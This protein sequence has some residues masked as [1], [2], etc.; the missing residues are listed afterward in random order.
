[1]QPISLSS[2]GGG[3]GL[4]ISPMKMLVFAGNGTRTF[5]PRT[6][7]A[8]GRNE[9]LSFSD[10]V[11]NVYS[12]AGTAAGTLNASAAIGGASQK[13]IES[14]CCYSVGD[15]CWYFLATSTTGCRLVKALPDGTITTPGAAFVFAPSLVGNFFYESGANVVFRHGTTA[16][17]TTVTTISKATG[18]IVTTTTD[19]V[20]P[21]YVSTDG[22]VGFSH[23]VF[24]P[25]DAPLNPD[26]SF[27]QGIVQ[28]H[29]LYFEPAAGIALHLPVMQLTP[30]DFFGLMDYR[31]ISTY[32][33]NAGGALNDAASKITPVLFG[34]AICFGYTAP[35]NMAKDFPHVMRT[36]MDRWLRDLGKKFQYY[37][38]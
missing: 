17:G 12:S 13:Y 29:G 8:Y 18:Q 6:V 30:Q 4:G 3:F 36:E 15:S 20:R 33:V 2:R 38:E 25:F 27:G 16:A 22:N 7:P 23:I 14:A 26:T 19:N 5:A 9:R 34:N 24:I 32:A 11:V 21:A 1:M 37:S 35:H 31:H 28:I 10:G